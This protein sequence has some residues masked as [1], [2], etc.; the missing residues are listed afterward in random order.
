MEADGP[1]RRGEAWK[2][3]CGDEQLEEKQG[4]ATASVLGQVCDEVVGLNKGCWS[5]GK[6][7]S[8]TLSLFTLF[9]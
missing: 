3:T 1:G 7:A 8:A 4:R 6:D 9:P 5:L 2:V